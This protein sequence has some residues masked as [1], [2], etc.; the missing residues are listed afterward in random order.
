MNKSAS[1][2]IVSDNCI[3]PLGNTTQEAWSKMINGE[4]AVKKFAADSILPEAYQASKWDKYPIYATK[5]PATQLEQLLIASIE[6]A[7]KDFP[8]DLSDASVIFV[9]ATTKGNI[10][11]LANKAEGFESRERPAKMAEFISQYFENPNTPWLL[12]NACISGLLALET[13]HM[14]LQNGKYKHAVVF[15]G[16]LVSKFIL[17]G[18]NSFKAVSLNPCKPFDEN[19]DGISLGEAVATIVLSSEI[20]SDL[21]IL[22]AATSN[23]ANHISGPSRDGSGLKSAI[24]KVVGNQVPDFISAHGTATPYND[25]M[26]ALAIYH[27]GFEKVPTHSIKSYVGHTLGAA[28]LLESCI[29]LESMRQSKAPG[30]KGFSKLGVSVPVNII[31]TPFEGEIKLALKTASGFGGCNAAVLFAKA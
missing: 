24:E 16:D 28:G 10:D 3:L 26:E 25:E 11:L 30:T 29:L 19:R 18:F 15:G 4:S 13:A 20:K 12:S 6:A 1:T 21:R 17:S 22:N 14:L 9:G 7:T 23:D 5:K 8:V 27:S 31:K 2:Y